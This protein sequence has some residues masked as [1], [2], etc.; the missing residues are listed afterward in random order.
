MTRR[1]LVAVWLYLGGLLSVLGFAQQPFTPPDDVSFRTAH[2][3]SEGTRIGAE[4]HAPQAA[5]PAQK[6]PAIIMGHGW[7]GTAANLRN[8]A[9][10]FA[11]AGYLVVVFDYRGWGSSDSRLLLTGPAPISKEGN[12]FTAEVLEVREVVDPIDQ[13]TDWL[14]VIHWVHGEPQVDTSRIGLWGS[15]YSG[16]LV[17]SAAA[18]DPR[19][20]AIVSQV[21]AMGTAG[22]V[23]FGA[24]APLAFEEATRRTRG[25]IGYP[26]PR[27]RVVGTLQGGPVREKMLY[28][29]PLDDI[30]DASHA[31]MLFV[32]AEKE[33]LFDNQEH[34]VKAHA[35]AKGPKRLVTLPGIT[36]YSIYT[37]ARG[38]ATTLAIDWFNEHLKRAR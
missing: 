4:I 21:G 36:H 14:N 24:E 19:V 26:A 17:V 18:R 8:T 9:A 37:T 35:R 32:I 11:R 25:E 22:L 27:A 23:G 28:Y 33:E 6:L 29:A 20:K 30:D 2:I 5:S 15:S 34:A 16:G 31:A 3:I 1:R 13:L 7:G 12:R 10:D 38:E